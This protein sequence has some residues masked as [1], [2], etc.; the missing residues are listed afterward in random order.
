MLVANNDYF[1]KIVRMR[2]AIMLQQASRLSQQKIC[3]KDG[4]YLSNR[5]YLKKGGLFDSLKNECC[6]YMKFLNSE[7]V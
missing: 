5:K 1:K 4:R 7:K 2:Q 3:K 6:C